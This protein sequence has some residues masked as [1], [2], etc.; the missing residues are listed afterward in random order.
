MLNTFHEN[1][2]KVKKNTALKQT[3]RECAM[4]RPA[5]CKPVLGV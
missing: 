2:F 1:L 3:D 4:M 5:L